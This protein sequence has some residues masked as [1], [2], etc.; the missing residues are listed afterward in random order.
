MNGL[1]P[2]N[3]PLNV[4]QTCAA[5]ADGPPGP[6]SGSVQWFSRVYGVL[7]VHCEAP[8]G[9]M[10]QFIIAHTGERPCDEFRFQGRLGFGGKYRRKTNTVDCYPEDEN[11]TRQRL[12]A[13]TNAALDALNTQGQ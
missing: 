5:E 7:M 2:H 4:C 13:E 1:C 9:M 11:P 10:Q 8:L 6:V 12:I 3:N